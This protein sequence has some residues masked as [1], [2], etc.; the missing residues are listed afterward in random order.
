M[1]MMKTIFSI[2]GNIGSGKSTLLSL[3]CNHVPKVKVI[4][5]PVADWQ[6]ISKFNLLDQYYQEPHRW[7]YTFQTNAILSRMKALRN[8]L[9]EMEM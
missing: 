2:E 9:K 6:N 7:A 3:I 1:S 4:P 5:E 8:L